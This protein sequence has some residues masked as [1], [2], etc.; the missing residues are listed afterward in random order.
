MSRWALLLMCAALGGCTSLG[1]WWPGAPQ[2][3]AT[4]ADLPAARVSPADTEVP[5]VELDTIAHAYRQALTLQRNEAV[6]ARV[7]LRLADLEMLLAEQALVTG[8]GE[9]AGAGDTAVFDT[10]IASY[11]ELLPSTSVSTQRDDIL[12]QLA[13]A[14]DL[15]GDTK[16]TEATLEQLSAG[17]A[18]SEHY[19]EAQ[20]RLAETYFAAARYGLA[21]QA[22]AN[23]IAAGKDGVH[24]RSALYMYA[25]AQFKQAAYAQSIPSFSALLDEV[26]VDEVLVDGVLVDEFLLED[27]SADDLPRAQREMVQDS[28][29]VMA[30]AVSYLGGVEYL[31]SN[32][33]ELAESHWHYLFY[34]ALGNLYLTQERYRDSA[35]VFETYVLAQPLS[36]HAHRFQLSAIDAYQQGEFTDLIIAAKQTY[37][38][39]Y[40]IGSDYW[41]AN[42]ASTREQVK[43]QLRLFVTE[44]ATYFHARA[45][46]ADSE[47]M[48]MLA[49][50][51]YDQYVTSF[52]EADDLPDMM[53]LLAEVRMASG[54]FV[55]AIRWFER[56]AYEF[57]A[58]PQAADAGYAAVLAYDAYMAELTAAEQALY[59]TRRTDSDL[60]FASR[61]IDDDRAGGVLRRACDDLYSSGDYQGAIIACVSL[62]GRDSATREQQVVAALVIGQSHFEL[63]QYGS[64]ESAFREGL[65]AMAVD[66]ERY[67]DAVDRIAASI[68][69]QAEIASVAGEHAAAGAEYARVLTAAPGTEIAA[70]AQFEA[71]ASYT[72]AQDWRQA[73]T[74]LLDFTARYPSHHLT[75]DIPAML[76]SNFE[77]LEQWQAAAQQLDIVSA[78]AQDR[79]RQGETL[80]LAAQYYQRAGEEATAIARYRDYAHGWPQPRGLNMEAMHQLV[81]LYEQ[82][83]NARKQ[84]YWL[85]KIVAVA[86]PADDPRSA[87]IGASAAAQLAENKYQAFQD[88]ALRHP[89]KRSL[90]KKKQAMETTL[91]AYRRVNDYAVQEFSTQATYRIGQV[92][93]DLSVSLLAS[94][95]PP[96]LDALALEQYELLLEEQ[97]YPFE[98]KAIAVYESNCQR[99]WQGIYDHWV[100]ASFTQLAALLPVRYGKT[101]DPGGPD[102]EFRALLAAA[103]DDTEVEALASAWYTQLLSDPWLGSESFAEGAAA[104]LNHYGLFLRQRAQFTAS[105]DVYLKALEI[106]ETSAPLHRNLG[107]L[108]DLY[109]GERESALVHFHRYQA[110]SDEQDR[111]V[112]AWIIDLERQLLV[113]ARED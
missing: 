94:E 93:Q 6:R 113:L 22:Y 61:F 105:R 88:L 106:Y 7:A 74:L 83:D 73:N 104:E 17:H 107:V 56:I 44:L 55:S 8:V 64:A 108:Y 89:L 36:A 66:D 98:E 5:Q 84:S 71:A 46:E 75:P 27:M 24:Y 29:R 82:P 86:V 37:T 80:Y 103:A 16:N 26:L 54:D 10:A 53:F 40:A 52:P 38:E 70:S 12:Y 49:G 96:E 111:A 14:Y 2:P 45:Q 99:A 76:V 19:P 23:V 30:L 50:D 91:A 43:P 32:S 65:A 35:A 11:R 68:Y 20:F 39:N 51:Y 31:T 62:A 109:L 72:R 67:P 69:R 90:A 101:E 78:S 25:W 42:N 92:Y 41:Q 47:A 77:Q 1:S 15:K 85:D 102:G 95:R 57:D 3:E 63:A 34:D 9:S 110:L 58:Y 21:Q 33:A 60:R 4:I 79:Q 13:K 18:D 28:L 48:Y 112:A 81:T 97:A 87:Y 100:E 59:R